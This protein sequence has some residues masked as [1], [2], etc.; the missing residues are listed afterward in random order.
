MINYRQG[1]VDDATELATLSLLMAQMQE[2]KRNLAYAHQIL[3]ILYW[4]KEEAKQALEADNES[5]AV[6]RN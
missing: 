6:G 4:K 3:G 5:R 1:K 2:D